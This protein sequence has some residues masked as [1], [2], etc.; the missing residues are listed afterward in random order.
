MKK[1]NKISL[2]TG[3]L[4]IILIAIGIFVGYTDSGN[5]VNLDSV[6]TS[7]NSISNKKVVND[8]KSLF[9][10]SVELKTA[11]ANVY[12]V[13]VYEGL[14]MDELSAKL[15]RVLGGVLSGK[16][17]LIANKCIE[18]GIDP[19]LAVAI[20]IHETGN[21]T[22]RI[23]RTC[24]NVGGQK[25]SGCG[26]YQSFATIDAGITGMINNLYKN[27]YSKGLNTVSKIGPRYAASGTWQAKIN[28]FINK[29]RA[30]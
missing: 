14:T 7:V 17:E 3:T 20:M 26:S 9:A 25:G 29:I 18:L 22:S 19:Y 30:A 8:N 10:N 12:R 23:S 2:I 28:G 11:E 21:G 4:G 27:F 15:N 6:S 16:G 5:T 1:T 13:E 24:N